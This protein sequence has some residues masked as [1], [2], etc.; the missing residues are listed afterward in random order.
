MTNKIMFL[1]A[2]VNWFKIFKNLPTIL[3]KKISLIEKNFFLY[4]FFFILYMYFNKY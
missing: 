3:R 4:I 1:M 2:L